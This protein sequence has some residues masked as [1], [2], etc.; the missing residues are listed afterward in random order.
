[1]EPNVRYAR[2]ADGVRIAFWTLGEGTALVQLP[3][4]P[5]S[6][7]QLEWQ[8]P[9]FRR[10][11]DGLARG[12]RL[13]R[14]DCRAAGLSDRTIS[15]YSLDALALDVDAVVE[16]LG[17]GPVDLFAGLH[18]GPVAI[19]YAARR[20]ER[21]SRLILWCT[22]TRAADLYRLP[23][24]EAGE[25]LLEVDWELYTET[26]AHALAV[27]WAEG[28]IA[29][30]LASYLR[31]CVTQE[32]AAR[33][34][35]AIHDFDVRA[36][37]PGVRAATLVLH[38]RHFAP[39]EVDVAREL[40]SQI[41]DAR[42]AVMEGTS[43]A[44]LGDDMVATLRVVEEFLTGSAAVVSPATEAG[45]SRGAPVTI[46]FTDAEGSTAMT[47]RLGDDR[48]RD[49]LRTYERIVREA[50]EA[51]AGTEVKTTGD[52]FMAAFSSATR[53]LQCAVELQRA[54]AEHNASSAEPLRVRIGL[55]AGEPIAENKDLFGTAVNLA[56]R[57]CAHAAAG[58]ILASNVVRELTAGKGF[59][60]VDRG[61]ARLR[62][63][64]E[65]VRLY[66]VGW[67]G[68]ACGGASR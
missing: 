18:A 19:A 30:R 60:F 1:M 12:R 22:Y 67:R 55:N 44:P 6:H 25:A 35:R 46:L 49:V 66:E 65:P 21:V 36:L 4:V 64:A 14:Y 17:P 28:E 34:L 54:F 57:L 68:E 2:T 8:I 7:V 15:E 26:L 61:T 51:N 53:A 56:A 50:L 31:D 9:P 38:R 37:L 11:Y 20:P 23:Q 42:L 62:G 52:G 13:V 40:A 63:F 32:M 59:V 5:F 16:R 27:G 41:P 3:M 39:L 10:W 33:A 24:V 43:L 45:P 58:Q 48:A 47:E 29:H